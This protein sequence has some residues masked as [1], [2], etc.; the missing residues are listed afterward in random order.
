MDELSR[1]VG[2]AFE[3]LT[4]SSKRQISCLPLSCSIVPEMKPALEPQVSNPVHA[5][6]TITEGGPAKAQPLKGDSTAKAQK[7]LKG[8]RSKLIQTADLLTSASDEPTFWRANFPSV[9]RFKSLSQISARSHS[10]R[11]KA[12]HGRAIKAMRRCVDAA[13]FLSESAAID[14]SALEPSAVRA[15]ALFS[16]DVRRIL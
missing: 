4:E 3:P 11:L 5:E 1:A 14:P 6:V 16:K 12:D 10:G 13:L 15:L 2:V 9:Q 7:A 8:I